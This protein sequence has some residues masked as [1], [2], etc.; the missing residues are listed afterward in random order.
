MPAADPGAA[1]RD[2]ARRDALAE[3]LLPGA[4]AWARL[5]CRWPI[6]AEQVAV[7]AAF[8]VVRGHDDRPLSRGYLKTRLRARHSD[9]I[10]HARRWMRAGTVPLAE[11]SE[12]NIPAAGNCDPARIAGDADAARAVLDGLPPGEL[13][14]AEA[15]MGGGALTGAD[16]AAI[17][18]IRAK[19]RGPNPRE[20]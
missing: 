15:V 11:G 6:D 10:R 7:D 5:N 20:R 9:A 17:R 2:A 12:A 13:R 14:A 8:D 18:R 1:G 19:F 3:A 16:R 4:F